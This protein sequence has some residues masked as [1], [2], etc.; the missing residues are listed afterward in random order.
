MRYPFILAVTAVGLS[1]CAYSGT[2][3]EPPTLRASAPGIN[4]DMR[5]C[6]SEAAT[7]RELTASERELIA[8]KETARFFMQ[9]RPVVSPEGKP[10]LH[11]SALPQSSNE[12]ADRYAVC[13]LKRGYTWQT[14]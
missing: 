3:L 13:L 1:A 4:S 7:P 9:G 14:K 5:A 6:M 12:A 11:Q 2:F 8:G 10:A